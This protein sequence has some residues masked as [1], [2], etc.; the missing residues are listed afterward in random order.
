MSRV[1]FLG[2]LGT[3]THQAVLSVGAA[4]EGF[5]L[6]PLPT[7]AEVVRR[8]ASEQVDLGVVPIE[9][10][11][12]GSVNPTLDALVLESEGVQIVGETLLPIHQCLITRPGVALTEIEA[13]LSHPQGTA[14]CARFL[15]SE[16]PR[17]RL[18][19]ANS[20]ADAVRQVA[21]GTEPWAAISNRAAAEQYGAVVLREDIEDDP[22]NL[23]RFVWLARAGAPPGIPGAPPAAAWKTAL[24]FWGSGTGTAG[25]LV[26]CL[27]ELSARGVNMTRIESRPRK[28]ELGEYMFFVDCDGRAGEGPVAEALEALAAHVEV[29]RVLGSYPTA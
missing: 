29:L 7:I 15:R 27:S 12:E 16:L 4:A 10:S 22:G 26:S 5:A 3:F 20:T 24:V 17:A 6:I 14:Q 28:R 13:V 11:L 19:A 25:W 18:V 21:R 9:N 8:V 1:G 23:T 2:P